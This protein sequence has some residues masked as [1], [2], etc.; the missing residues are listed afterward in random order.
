MLMFLVGFAFIFVARSWRAKALEKYSSRVSATVIL[1]REVYNTHKEIRLSWRFLLYDT[2]YI[3]DNPH[4]R[5]REPR[6]RNHVGTLLVNPAKPSDAFDPVVDRGLWNPLHRAGV[7]ILLIWVVLQAYPY[8]LFVL[9]EVGIL[10][11]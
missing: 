8:V 9:Q 11:G 2:Y 10:H 3:F 1:S 6:G 5:H 4:G 7:V